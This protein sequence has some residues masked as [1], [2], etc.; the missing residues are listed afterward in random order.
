MKLHTLLAT[1]ALPFFAATA[2]AALVQ[3]IQTKTYAGTAGNT[4]TQV[5]VGP[6]MFNLFDLSKGVLQGVYLSYGVTISGGVSG[7]DNQTNQVVNGTMELGG[8]AQFESTRRFF[9]N[10]FQ[11]LFTPVSGSKVVNFSLAA[12]PTLSVGGSGPDVFSMTGSTFTGGLSQTQVNS[13][14]HSDFTGLGQ[15]AVDFRTF[16]ILQINAP[17]SRGFFDAPSVNLSMSLTYVYDAPEVVIPEPPA[18]VSGPFLPLAGGLVLLGAGALR[19][20]RTAA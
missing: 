3:D 2:Q 7:A 5:G 8:S 4:S 10:T 15:F 20:K 13:L 16:S 14:F 1:L 9:S 11:S 6:L 17:G 12:D 19:R 18:D